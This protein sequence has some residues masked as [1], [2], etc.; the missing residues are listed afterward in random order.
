MCGKVWLEDL[1]RPQQQKTRM[2]AERKIQINLATGAM[3]TA[4][5]GRDEGTVVPLRGQV[6]GPS[7]FHT[8]L[9]HSTNPLQR[10][11]F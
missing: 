5:H 11:A 1:P 10:E 4:S 2:P 6:R 8:K 9:L 3:H 7:S